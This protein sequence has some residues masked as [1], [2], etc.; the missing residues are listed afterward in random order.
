MN[1]N[2]HFK[3]PTEVFPSL[4]R[5][6]VRKEPV[7]VVCETDATVRARSPANAADS[8]TAAP[9]V[10]FVTMYARDN[11]TT[12]ANS[13]PMISRPAMLLPMALTG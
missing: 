8:L 10:S 3:R 5:S 12:V 11:S 1:R 13:R 6:I 2:E 4:R 9:I 7:V